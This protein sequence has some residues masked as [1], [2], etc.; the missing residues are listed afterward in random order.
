MLFEMVIF[1]AIWALPQL[2]LASPILSDIS[3]HIDWLNWLELLELTSLDI[4]SLLW[5]L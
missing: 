4:K 1:H 5:E 2:C 3:W